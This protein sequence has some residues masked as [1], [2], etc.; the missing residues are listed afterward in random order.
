MTHARISAQVMRWL[1]AA[2]ALLSAAEV[3]A[4]VEVKGRVVDPEGNPVKGAKVYAI[5]PD[6]EWE[7]VKDAVT[8]DAGG[9]FVLRNV[10]DNSMRRGVA[11]ATAGGFGIGAVVIQKEKP[12]EIR[13]SPPI[14]VTVPFV[15]E[16][17]KPLRDLMFR[18]HQ[19]GFPSLDFR[20]GTYVRPPKDMQLFRGRTDGNGELRLG[21]LPRGGRLWLAVDDE[22]FARL[23]VDSTFILSDEEAMRAAP[24][25]L[26]K[27]ASVKGRLTHENGKPAGGI[28]IGANPVSSGTGWSKG[29]SDDEGFYELKKLAPGEYYILPR[30]KDK[31]LRKLWCAPWEK[32]KLSVGEQKRGV[33]LKL[34]SGGVIKGK[35]T[36]ADNGEP[37][38][39][40][41][42]GLYVGGK[43][44]SGEPVNATTTEVD[45]SYL[46]R[47][48]PGEHY[49]YL[50][51][52]VA[53]EG[54]SMPAQKD[55]IVRVADGQTVEEDW[56]LPRGPKNPLVSGRVVDEDGKAVGDCTIWIEPWES[57]NRLSY[58]YEAQSAAD[59]SYQF[60][61]LYP[62]VKV[63]AKKNQM[64][65]PA[66]VVVKGNEDQQ[67][68]LKLESNALAGI[69]GMV[70]DARGDLLVGAKIRLNINQGGMMGGL[71]MA[72][73]GRDGTF[74]IEGLWP[75]GWYSANI[76]APGRGEYKSGKL[77]LKPGE[78]LDLG[79]VQLKDID[80]F[81]SGTV[82]DAN[83]NPAA[84]IRVS[85]NGTK[86]TPLVQ[87]QTDRE[88]KFR[89][90]AVRG[91]TFDLFVNFGEGSISSR[92]VT[93]GEENIQMFPPV[94]KR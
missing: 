40:M 15:D 33:A 52:S 31:Q 56:K 93:A 11:A 73:T 1:V 12:I 37:I 88:G 34:I 10:E 53:P 20:Y 26:V 23:S 6:E 32:I 46:I 48:P 69:S 76:T 14:E 30:I 2:L 57:R 89:I 5:Q 91:D 86:M 87:T 8:S 4:G 58:P 59:G 83:G 39:E 41:H 67:L 45:G 64:A 36:A 35:V 18:T 19:I 7:V 27:A 60:K 80:S 94:R 17:G 55:R 84:G 28:E 44:T 90:P 50:M 62:Q 42:V 38:K 85:I 49:L 13:L 75:D 51:I 61:L 65:T 47:V 24:M 21:G 43:P 9:Q 79:K 25:K 74:K 63:R 92:K 3:A 68:D 71:A 54:F 70:V 72:S 66:A 22:R 16:E 29:V 81:I 78:I 77:E 82:F